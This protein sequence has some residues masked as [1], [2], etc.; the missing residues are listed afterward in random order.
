[1]QRKMIETL[2]NFSTTE[3][4][5]DFK[6]I[7]ELFEEEYKNKLCIV[8]NKKDEVAVSVITSW[9]RTTDIRV[10]AIQRMLS[11]GSH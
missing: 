11:T 9:K 4:Y 2:R 3:Q 5:S 10:N 6:G 8:I 1:M 7:R